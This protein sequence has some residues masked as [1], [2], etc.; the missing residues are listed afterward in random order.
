MN[1]MNLG[2]EQLEG[3]GLNDMLKQVGINDVG[4]FVNQ[5]R[6]QANEESKKGGSGGQSQ[7][8][9]LMSMGSSFLNQVSRMNTFECSIRR[10]ILF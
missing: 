7:Q 6:N 8:A 9:D 3:G 4:S 2:R 5:F 10:A 1:L